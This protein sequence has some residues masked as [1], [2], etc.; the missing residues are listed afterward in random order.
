MKQMKFYPNDGRPAISVSSVDDIREYMGDVINC[1]STIEIVNSLVI[2]YI[3]GQ[4]I[5]IGR[6]E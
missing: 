6:I 5:I 1:F 2:A 3:D 4:G